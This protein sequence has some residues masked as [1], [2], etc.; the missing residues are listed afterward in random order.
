MRRWRLP[1]AKSEQDK[2]M[3]GGHRGQHCK[4]KGLT[5]IHPHSPWQMKKK[6]YLAKLQKAFARK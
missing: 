5:R 4:K 1:S 3:P 2:L 6:L